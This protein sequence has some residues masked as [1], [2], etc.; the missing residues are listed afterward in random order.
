MLLQL[1]K[2]LAR[3]P[4]RTRGWARRA[5]VGVLLLITLLAGISIGGVRGQAPVAAQPLPPV[6]VPED[7]P[8]GSPLSPTP[9]RPTSRVDPTAAADTVTAA[10]LRA[11]LQAPVYEHSKRGHAAWLAACSPYVDGGT[12]GLLQ[13]A[14][15]S[16]VP[17]GPGGTPLSV[18]RVRG[19]DQTGDV[20]TLLATLSDGSTVTV[21]ATG[22]QSGWRVSGYRVP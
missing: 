18:V 22:Q 7:E 11:W 2:V 20:A 12:Y 10:F 21:T 1:A 9:A 4:A 8:P 14:E 17:T 6:A 13:L 15:T 5:G 19:V 3:D 16:G